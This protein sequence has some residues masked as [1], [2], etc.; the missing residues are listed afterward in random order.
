M[1]AQ[2]MGDWLRRHPWV[3]IPFLGLIPLAGL[4]LLNR[5]SSLMRAG[6]EAPP[7]GTAPAVS[8]SPATAPPVAG[9]GS[10]APGRSA[11]LI[12]SRSPSGAATPAQPPIPKLAS[13]PTAIPSP[14][15]NPAARPKTAAIPRQG[16]R[17]S[18]VAPL[19]NLSVDGAIE[20]HVAIA[21]GVGSLTIATSAGGEV[22]NA[23]KGSRLLTLPPQQRYEVQ[24]DGGALLVGSARLAPM[25]LVTPSPGGLVYVGDRA[26]RGQM[27]LYSENNRLWAVNYVNMQQYLYSV[28]GSEVS[29]SWPMHALKAQAVAARSY[30]LTYYLKPIS[31]L[32]HLGATEYYQVYKGIE[33]EADTTRQAVNGTGGEFVSYRGGVVESL[34]AATDDIV[35]EAFQ[36]KGMSQIGALNLAERGYTYRQIL[37]T[38]YTGTGVARIEMDME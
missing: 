32:Y 31:K 36:G 7:F 13:S 6:Q 14:L 28:V 20:M 37:S 2:V 38:Y 34:Y 15:N 11:G 30:A 5:D 18:G 4:A 23:Q 24:G 19:M 10:P 27:L 12:P 16:S 26:Y 1:K 3:V 25:V 9:F 21:E 22:I 33:S 35:M 17:S 29:P 8:V